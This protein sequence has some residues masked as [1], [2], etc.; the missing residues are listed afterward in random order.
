M[1]LRRFVGETSRAVL[2]QVRNVFGPD[3][4]IVSNRATSA[5]IEITAVSQDAI[6]G[7]LDERAPNAQRGAAAE[8]AA[9]PQPPSSDDGVHVTLSAQATRGANANAP[10]HEAQPA[11]AV[12]PPSVAPIAPPP[13]ASE[14]SLGDRLAD[15]VAAMRRL[16]TEQI[17]QLTL[18]DAL[19]R[20]PLRAR[21]LRELLQ[22]GY[23][24]ALARPLVQRIPDDFSPARANHWVTDALARSLGCVDP[25]QDLITRGGVYALVGPTGVGKTTTTAKLAARCA[26]RYGAASLALLTTDTYRVGGHDQLRIYARILGVSVQAVADRADLRQ[27]LQ[28][29]RGKHLVLIDTVGMGQ[30]DRRVEEQTA[31]LAEPEVRRVLLLNAA[32]QAETLDEVVCRYSKPTEAAGAH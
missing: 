16:L 8:G 5:G 6:A 3:A 11:V 23:S 17:E 2:E 19:K 12:A 30:R 28:A 21:A 9:T 18:T 25:E 32:A 4:I 31:V 22:A 1:K 26:V 27:A 29:A 24:P 15:E 14:P 20:S 10:A 13:A 7:L